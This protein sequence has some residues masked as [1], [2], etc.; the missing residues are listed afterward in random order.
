MIFFF[1]GMILLICVTT[2]FL[3]LNLHSL[4]TFGIFDHSIHGNLCT[5]KTEYKELFFNI[6]MWTDTILY[7]LAPS[8]IIVI[9]NAVIVAKLILHKIERNRNLVVD[10][11]GQGQHKVSSLTIMLVVVA[12]SFVVTTTPLGIHGSIFF[13][14]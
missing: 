7:S 8:C 11:G 12:T 4:I 1:S 3:M 2:F 5:M 9:C 6:W 10:Q 14:G 13:P